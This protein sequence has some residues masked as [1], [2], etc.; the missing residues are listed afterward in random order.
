VITGDEDGAGDVLAVGG[1]SL[2]TRQKAFD[3]EV[4]ATERALAW[5][6]VGGH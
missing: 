5:L 6:V 4:T 3:A 2:G 1:K